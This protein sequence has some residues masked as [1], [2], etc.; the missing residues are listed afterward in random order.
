MA[1]CGG[2]HPDQCSNPWA[3]AWE[4]RVLATRPS[5]S[6]DILCTQMWVSNWEDCQSCMNLFKINHSIAQQVCAC[7]A[8]APAL[9]LVLG[10]PSFSGPHL[11]PGRAESETWHHTEP[12]VSGT[13][14]PRSWENVAQDRGHSTLTAQGWG[15]KQPRL[16]TQGHSREPGQVAESMA[17]ISA[18]DLRN[19]LTPCCTPC[20]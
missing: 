10:A 2:L 3:P 12:G 8:V 6:L 13:S 14:D 5:G 19:P 17:N 1:A 18:P 16:E 20:A 4:R 15:H 9:P 7:Q 11:V